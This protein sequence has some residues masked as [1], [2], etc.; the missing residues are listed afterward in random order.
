[1]DC[2]GATLHHACHDARAAGVGCAFGGLFASV[3]IAQGTVLPVAGTEP[4]SELQ[5]A[6]FYAIATRPEGLSLISCL[7]WAFN[8]KPRIENGLL[9]CP[10][11]H[12]RAA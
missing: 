9:L 12:C 6:R 7:S 5:I 1:M 11:S 2:I 4:L 8:S 3:R 10:Q